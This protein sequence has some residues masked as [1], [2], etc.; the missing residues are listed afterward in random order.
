ML[1]RN[2][3]LVAIETESPSTSEE[4]I[5]NLTLIQSS[6]KLFNQ[7]KTQYNRIEC[8]IFVTN[9]L[10]RNQAFKSVRLENQT[11]SSC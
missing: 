9:D 4:H 5:G 10:E 1:K 7:W 2:N 6:L 3:L 11:F 8:L